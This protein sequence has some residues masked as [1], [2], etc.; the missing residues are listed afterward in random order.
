MEKIIGNIEEAIQCY[1]TE[2]VEDCIKIV[3]NLSVFMAVKMYNSE[4]MP[5]H[6]ECVIFLFRGLK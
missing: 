4:K 3:G 2:T 6:A 5:W 1:G